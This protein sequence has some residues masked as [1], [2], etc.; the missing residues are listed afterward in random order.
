MTKEEFLE[1]LKKAL[2]STGSASLIEEN[3]RFYSSY[4]DDEAAKGR[5]MD[6]IMEELGE[7]RLIANSIKVAH[8]YEDV[9]VG[10]NANEED[11]DKN[12]YSYEEEHNENFDKKEESGFKVYNLSGKS[13]VLPLII[14][15][16]VLIL[17]AV[18][19]VKV[20]KYL[21]PVLLP[22]LLILFIF[23]L[24]RGIFNNRN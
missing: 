18:V 17:V 6:D 10:L 13:L 8:G 15:L 1:G 4:I 22:I 23:V 3:I 16:V 9:F 11:V 5:S 7:P 14:T 21:A 24:I 19:V 20:L 12:T 2:F